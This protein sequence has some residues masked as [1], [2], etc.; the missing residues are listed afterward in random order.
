MQET[1]RR[2]LY[3]E[4]RISDPAVFL[5]EAIALTRYGK[6]YRICPVFNRQLSGTVTISTGVYKVVIKYCFIAFSA[7]LL[8]FKLLR[9]SYIALQANSVEIICGG[10]DL[11]ESV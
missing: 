1:L 5:Q 11:R 10:G 9:K 4:K 3:N 6:H 2:W 7:T 8:W